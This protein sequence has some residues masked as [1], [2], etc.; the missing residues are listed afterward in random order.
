[1]S[2]GETIASIGNLQTVDDIKSSVTKELSSV[3]ARVAGLIV[4]EVTC[5][6]VYIKLDGTKDGRVSFCYRI[7]Y[8]DIS[9]PLG[10]TTCNRLQ[11][12]VREE[13]SKLGFETTIMG[14]QC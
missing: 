12:L 10:K 13:V 3:L 7:T 8:N 11:L 9:G 5:I 4:L 6:D 14:P 2:T 1:M